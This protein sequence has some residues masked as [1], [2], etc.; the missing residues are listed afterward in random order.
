MQLKL[1]YGYPL[2]HDDFVIILIERVIAFE[3][4]GVEWPRIGPPVLCPTSPALGAMD[5]IARPAHFSA[6]LHF[7]PQAV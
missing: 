5:E 3:T 6:I 7:Q 1:S 2:L 4:T